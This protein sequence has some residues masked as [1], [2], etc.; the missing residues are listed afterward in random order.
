MSITYVVKD[1]P[2]GKL[3]VASAHLILR[4]P[5]AYLAVTSP[6]NSHTWKLRGEDEG[7]VTDANITANGFTFSAGH[8][9]ANAIVWAG[10]DG[11]MTTSAGFTFD[12]TTMTVPNITISGNTTVISTQN[13][14]VKDPL[15]QIGSNV[16][17]TTDVGFILSSNS[18]SGSNVAIGLENS[19]SKEFIIG[20][21]QTGASGE[22]LNVDT[23]QSINVHVYG[24]VIASSFYGNGSHLSGL[25]ASQIGGLTAAVEDT[26]EN[27]TAFNTAVGTYISANPADVSNL[28]EVTTVSSIT[29]NTITVGGLNVTSN[30]FN[31][32]YV[33]GTAS[34]T[35]AI[36]GNGIGK[37]VAAGVDSVAIGSYASAATGSI[38][39]NASGAALSGSSGGFYAKPVRKTD[40]ASNVMGYTSSGE[41]IDTGIVAGY[42]PP[43]L[44][45]P[46]SNVIGAQSNVQSIVNQMQTIQAANIV[47]LYSGSDFTTNVEAQ[48]S[49][50]S[51][52]AF[53][54]AV[55]TISGTDVPNT[56]QSITDSGNTTSQFI[57]T[58]GL[59]TTNGLVNNVHI[60]GLNTD[61]DAI[62]IGKNA[63]QTLQQ[64]T[65]AI[66]EGA[67]VNM[68][69][70]SIAIGYQAGNDVQN[71]KSIVIGYQAGNDQVGTAS[72]AIGYQAGMSTLADH[73][74]VLNATGGAFD[75]ATVSGFYVKPV[76]KSAD[77]SNIMGYTSN[78]E[79]IDTG[80]VAGAPDQA[81]HV[82]WGDVVGGVSNVTVLINNTLTA[83]NINGISGLYSNV[84]FI[85]NVKSLINSSL[86]SSNIDNITGLYSAP[87]FVSNVN[88]LISASASTNSTLQDVTVNGAS[89]DRTVNLSNA[90]TGLTTTSNV[91]VGGQLKVTGN[92]V[93]LQSLSAPAIATDTIAVNTVLATN[94]YAT[95]GLV[96]TG[97]VIASK[98]VDASGA[99]VIANDADIHN[100]LTV[101]GVTT[102]SILKFTPG[103]IDPVLTSAVPTFTVTNGY[104]N[105]SAT[106]VTYGS[107]TYNAASG[108]IKG[109]VI[110]G[111][112]ANAHI[113]FYVSA[114]TLTRDD[115]NNKY[116]KPLA[117][118]PYANILFH[119]F[120]VPGVGNFIDMASVN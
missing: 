24:N 81:S 90:T 77:T 111:L 87:N 114:L 41:I 102:V 44:S 62:A 16:L 37:A 47:G 59:T 1:D 85:S 115:A 21:T 46:W 4:Q 88:S 48:F 25:S 12:G 113:Y 11:A 52:S 70:K 14:S 7:L 69:S 35:V 54:N 118:G 51:G 63:N 33:K 84:N 76:R 57:T 117:N 38:V 3:N 96:S 104:I 82:N 105:L 71:T 68:A 120:N 32:L 19:N 36:G 99:T 27:N 75:N 98:L 40:A 29:T 119:I 39:L 65:I 28:H 83:S 34:N 53:Y 91:T 56:L 23:A 58:G 22:H 78:G 103:G 112:A 8:F 6:D 42:V 94:V 72:I 79:I 2:I 55:S 73:A 95:G 110:T 15:I 116:I 64:N 30:L 49:T 5:G 67:G 31:N 43:V 80:I 17:A 101:G 74:I 50:T 18:I 60:N 106:G 20:R 107:N 109:F 92:I 100:N 97:T 9:A 26:F 66:G 108:T 86:T 89:S 13:L 93:S 61:F 10:Y 45:I